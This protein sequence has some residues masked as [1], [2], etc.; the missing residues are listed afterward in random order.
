MVPCFALLGIIFFCFFR[1]KLGEI[2]VKKLN[3]RKKLNKIVQLYG[4]VS[5]VYFLRDYVGIDEQ[6]SALENATHVDVKIMNFS[7]VVSIPF[8]IVHS[9]DVAIGKVILVE[10]YKHNIGAYINPLRIEENID[11]SCDSTFNRIK[12]RN[13]IDKY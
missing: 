8:D 12:R 2:M 10:D 5:M 9:D 3:N 11:K 1:R 4:T 7:N 13:Y 6:L